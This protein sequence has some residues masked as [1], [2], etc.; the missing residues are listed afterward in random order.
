MGNLNMKTNKIKETIEFKIEDLKSELK[1][2]ENLL[3]T[4]CREMAMRMSRISEGLAH[5]GDDYFSLN[6]IGE[7]QGDGGKIDA[8]VGQVTAF[9]QSLKMMENLLKKIN[10]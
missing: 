6:S 10:E 5:Q 7:A 1:Y 2:K 8:L 9:R 3:M 4:H